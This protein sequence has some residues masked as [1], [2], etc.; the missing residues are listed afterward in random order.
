M[1]TVN[2]I[3][4]GIGLVFSVYKVFKSPKAYFT[5]LFK[6]PLDK[7]KSNSFFIIALIVALYSS[8]IY[9]LGLGME[10]AETVTIVLISIVLLWKAYEVLSHPKLYFFGLFKKYDSDQ[11][12]S[13]EPLSMLIMTGVILVSYL[14][15]A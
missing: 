2:W 7:S 3:V 6:S 11:R 10:L 4:L 14:L 15:I 1:E 8:I 13:E 9:V 12:T 5:G